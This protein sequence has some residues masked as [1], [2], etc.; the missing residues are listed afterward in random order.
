M[1]EAQPGVIFLVVAGRNNDPVVPQKHRLHHFVPQYRPPARGSQAFGTEYRLRIRGI[2]FRCTH[3]IMRRGQIHYP[4]RQ[5]LGLD[6]APAARDPRY[7]GGSRG[8]RGSHPHQCVHH[9][10]ELRTATREIMKT[11]QLGTGSAP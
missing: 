10:P 6:R 11:S 8:R 1:N 9:G 7:P 2:A 3:L 5:P 4:H